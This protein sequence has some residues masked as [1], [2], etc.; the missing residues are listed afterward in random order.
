MS[1]DYYSCDSCEESRYEEYVATCSKCFHSVCTACVVNDDIESN[2]AYEYGTK[3]DGS[4]S[5]REEFGI[6]DNT[7]EI[8]EIID[9]TGI[10]PKYCPFCSGNEVHNDDLLILALELLKI[11]KQDLILEYKNR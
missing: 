8:G 11:T 6:E 4:E 9:D 1:V 5:Q 3:Y 10:D 2:C 7:Y